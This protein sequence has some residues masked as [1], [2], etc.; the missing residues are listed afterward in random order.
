MAEIVVKN[1]F[2]ERIMR[3]GIRIRS[4][5][6]PEPGRPVTNPY[7]EHIRQAGGVRLRARSGR[8]RA[9]ESAGPTETRSVR[10]PPA[11]W[12]RVEA[13]AEREGLT[14]HAAVRQAVLIWLKS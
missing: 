7:Y 5:R 6:Q 11:V 8:P 13:Q 1:P 4:E 3:D 12:A 14:V 9:G 10:L 2:Y